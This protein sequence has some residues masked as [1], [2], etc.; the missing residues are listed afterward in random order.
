MIAPRD[1]GLQPERTLLS[2]RRTL[3]AVAVGSL[4]SLRV[5]EPLLGVGALV[6]GAAGLV[7]AVVLWALAARRHRAVDAVFREEAPRSAMPGGALLLA[8]ALLA[9][10]GAALALLLLPLR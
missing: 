1:P 7:A 6:A 4:L 9:T 10:T 3:L 8:L 2:W 5:L